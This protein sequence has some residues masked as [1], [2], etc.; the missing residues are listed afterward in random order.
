LDL[1]SNSISN[2]HDD[3]NGPLTRPKNVPIDDLVHRKKKKRKYVK[4]EKVEEICKKRYDENALGITFEDITREF[5][6]RKRNAQRTLKHFRMKKVL[7]TAEDLQNRM[8]L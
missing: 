2:R 5:S 3:N 8:S 7:F 1:S 4:R 6:V